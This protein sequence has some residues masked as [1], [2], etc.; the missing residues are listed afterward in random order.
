MEEALETLKLDFRSAL[1]LSEQLKE[2][3]RLQVLAG[4]LPPGAQLPPIRQ[5]AVRLNLNP[6]TVAKV[7]REL[8]A[9]RFIENHPGRGCFVA[10]RLPEDADEERRDALCREMRRFLE[11]AGTLGYSIEEIITIMREVADE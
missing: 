3:L 1:P 9:E 7:Y 10:V 4:R 8:E 11:R 6:N 5:L 2:Q